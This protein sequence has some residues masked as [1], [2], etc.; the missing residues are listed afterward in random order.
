MV[1]KKPQT[2]TALQQFRTWLTWHC[3]Y[4]SVS[5]ILIVHIGAFWNVNISFHCVVSVPLDGINSMSEKSDFES[6]TQSTTELDKAVKA[7]LNLSDDVQRVWW[8]LE[9]PDKIQIIHWRKQSRVSLEPDKLS[10]RFLNNCTVPVNCIVTHV[11]N[12][13]GRML[14]SRPKKRNEV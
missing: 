9:N 14:G 12:P 4:A 1:H 7:H 13:T 2:T 3:L 8:V 5:A 10:L 11:R 6:T